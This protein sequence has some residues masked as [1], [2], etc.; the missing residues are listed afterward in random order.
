MT[1]T[2]V[3]H[4]STAELL[5]HLDV[6]DAAPRDVGTLDLIVIRPAEGERRELTEGTLDLDRGLLGDTWSE[7]PSSRSVDGGPHADMQLNV[8]SSRV[9]SF[10]AGRD[11]RRALA[12]DQLYLDL[13]L[14]ED[15]LPAGTRLAI[16]DG[17]AVIEVT[18]EPHTGCAKF[19]ER[20]GVEAMSFV[21]GRE[22]RPRRLRGL[23]A[24]VV[25][26]GVIRPGD[27]VVVQRP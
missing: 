3:A 17:G 18:A 8:M 6:I 2:P 24:K 19:I 21:N 10:I 27:V 11:D 20:F 12:G 4:R 23:N 13:N 22:G 5:A 25:T 16:G 14:S 15:N 7:R 26:G 1:S 9:V